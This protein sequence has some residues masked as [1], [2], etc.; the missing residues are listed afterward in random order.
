MPSVLFVCTGNLFRSPIAAAAF[1]KR[2][3]D[4]GG[5][6]SWRVESAGTWAAVG[7]PP[8]PVAIQAAAVCG[9]SL[10]GHTTRM[11]EAS[12]L[13][14]SDLILVMEGGQ[15]EAILIEFPNVDG[16]VFLLSEFAEGVAYDIPDPLSIEEDLSEEIAKEVCALVGKGFRRI[17]ELAQ[18]LSDRVDISH[19]GST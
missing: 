16:R 9:L 15:K 3:D 10:K 7:Q 13:S 12:L 17:C 14:S 8:L 1:L 5:A 4:E 19:S 11:V 2:L 18:R 6:A